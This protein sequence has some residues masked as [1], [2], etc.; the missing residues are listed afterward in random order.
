MAV[1]GELGP[2]RRQSTRAVRGFIF[3]LKPLSGVRSLNDGEARTMKRI[4]L[5]VALFVSLAAPAWAGFDEGL[6]AYQRG[7]YET[8]LREL[9]PLAEQGDALAQAKLGV[10]YHHG[11]GVPQDYAEA[12]KWFCRAAEQGYAV[13]QHNLGVMYDKGQGVP[14]DYAEALRWYR[15]AAEQ[16]E[17]VAQRGIGRMYSLGQ[18]VPQDYGEA[19]K[20]YRRAAE[21]GEAVAQSVLGTMYADGSGVPQDYVLA[22][23]WL[24]LGAAASPPGVQRD[25]AVAARDFAAESMTPAQIAKAQRLARE[26]KP[27][28]E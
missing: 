9:K 18:G 3:G 27:K 28:K 2:G 16:G 6:A 26:W 12:A 7:D 8:A 14:Q 13:A 5:A 10:M 4:A 24:N 23:I 15:R 20:W 11:R 25:M 17:A 22:H 19:A 21:Q 1:E